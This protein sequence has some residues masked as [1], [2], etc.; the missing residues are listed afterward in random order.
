[1]TQILGWILAVVLIVGV[2]ILIVWLKPQDILKKITNRPIESVQIDGEFLY[3]SRQR[4]EEAIVGY[5]DGGFLQLDIN[6]LKERLELNP[7]VD[8]VSVARLW[9]DV[10]RITI[11]EQQPIARWG[12]E[13]FLNMRGDIVFV[14][15]NDKL[16]SLPLLFGNNRYAKQ[17]MQQ[18][19]FIA[20]L[21]GSNA[22]ALTT[23]QLDETMSWTLEFDNDLIVRLGREQVLEK[24][25]HL[26]AAS[27]GA[28]AGRIADIKTID[29]RYTN[30]FSVAW[31]EEDEQQPLT[32][33][34]E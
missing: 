29:M 15:D 17:V 34:L 1:M 12:S 5:I 3:L 6:T 24:L 9:P 10:L 4:T 30:G 14:E 33:S 13:G 16:Q 22:G 18:Y 19:L 26:V 21:M 31:K 28:L 7:W 11:I 2:V 25:Q 20:K 8:R 32:W 27:R 23:V